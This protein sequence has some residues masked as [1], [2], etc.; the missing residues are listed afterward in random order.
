MPIRVQNNW[1]A[2]ILG[3]YSKFYLF[4]AVVTHVR[5]HLAQR[6]NHPGKHSSLER[7]VQHAYY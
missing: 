3:I 5:D 2:K 6:Q 7:L 1:D 4:Y